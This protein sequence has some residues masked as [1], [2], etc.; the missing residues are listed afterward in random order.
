MTKSKLL[1]EQGCYVM[2]DC[3]MEKKASTPEQH[4]S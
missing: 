2:I 4:S 1:Y 3:V